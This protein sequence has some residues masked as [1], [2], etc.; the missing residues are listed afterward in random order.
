L[1][2]HLPLLILLILLMPGVA[3]AASKGCLDCHP[4]HHV[5]RGGCI[6]CHRGNDLTDRKRIAHYRLIPARYASFTLPGSDRVERGKKLV[7]RFGCRR[8]HIADKHGTSLAASLEHL[9]AKAPEELAAAI[10]LPAYYMPDFR[11][12]A[13]DRDDIVNY[14]MWL[15]HGGEAGGKETPVVIHFVK[16]EREREHPFVKRCG[17]CHKVLTETIG[18]VGRGAVGPNITALFTPFYPR[19]YRKGEPWTTERLREWLKNP[20]TAR[21]AAVMPPVALE[22][23]ELEQ[24]EELLTVTRQFSHAEQ[25][26]P[27]SQRSLPSQQP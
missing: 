24:I 26:N 23:K 3:E 22:A 21:P 17:G 15:G 27:G 6:S 1:V 19:L 18:G 12:S 16:K 5:D 9:G 20:R 2:T 8:C 10:D 4:A 25:R 11:F 7:E 14:L 13:A